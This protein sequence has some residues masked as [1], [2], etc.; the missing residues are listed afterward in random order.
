MIRHYDRHPVVLMNL[1]PQITDGRL[2]VQQCLCGKSPEC[3]NHLRFDQFD[4]SNQVRRAC[5]NLVRLR[6]PVTWWAM[7]EDVANENVLSLELDRFEN[8]RQQLSSRADEL[9]SRFIF[10]RARRFADHHEIRAGVSF[11]WNWIE[12]GRVQ[13]AA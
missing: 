5:P 11:T 12:R 3:E 9:P 13:R 1:A 4:L 7:L 2:T 10:G 8:L 6:I